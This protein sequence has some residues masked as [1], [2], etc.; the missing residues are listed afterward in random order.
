MVGSGDD[1]GGGG[2]KKKERC[3]VNMMAKQA[4][5]VVICHKYKNAD[6]SG[7]PFLPI[8]WTTIPVHSSVNS[9]IHQNSTRMENTGIENLAELSA[10]FQYFTPPPHMF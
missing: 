5:F 7:I 3:L 10:K 1:Y 6:C 9:R 2:G 8:L 4:L